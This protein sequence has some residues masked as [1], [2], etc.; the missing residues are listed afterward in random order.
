MARDAER[1]KT[2]PQGSLQEPQVVIIGAGP[3]GMVLAYLLVTNGISVRVL[4]RHPDFKREF[5]VEGIQPSV[6]AVLDDLGFLPVLLQKGIAIPAQQAKIFLNEELVVA[7]G[8]LEEKTDNF[9]L[10]VFQE[11]FLAFLDELC[12]QYPGYRLDMGFSVTE[13]VLKDG[14]VTAV[15]GRRKG[16]GE[17]RVEAELFIAAS[18]RN[19]NLRKKVGIE[20]EELESTFNIYWL[21]FDPPSDPS[22]IP[23]GFHAYLKDD[24]MFI[25][26]RTYD[27]KIQ[28]AW[29][30]RDWDAKAFRDFDSLKSRMV[31]EAPQGYQAMVADQFG[32]HIERQLL[33][34]AADRMKKWS[35]PG[36]LFIGDA[37]HT[38]SP[39]AGQ[40]INLA[41]RDSIVAAN[42]LIKAYRQGL[43][44]TQSLLEE[45]EAERRPE[46]EELQAFQVRL[47]YL[48]LGAPRW[49]TRL[50][51][52]QLM[53]VL[54]ALGIRQ[55][56]VR[57]VQG[58]RSKVEVQFPVRLDPSK[59]R[60]STKVVEV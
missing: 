46:V 9:G 30:K 32:E 52:R 24:S 45:I 38:M 10:I 1:M 22:L 33:K 26:Y 23:D 6:M 44:W 42:H 12:S 11:G 16:G 50:V 5:R 48:M 53:P 36:M 40:G 18:G 34:V 60:P 17:E 47:G 25:F 27:H 3:A 41:I 4:E 29:G 58:G 56:Y 49:Q 55:H 19:T 15:L 54:S 21:K 28:V 51:F 2:S 35:L 43:P 57:R 59:R 31:A 39:V 20:V 13:P 37:A 7:L 14:R 8:G